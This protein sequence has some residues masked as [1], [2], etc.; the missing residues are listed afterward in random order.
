M[1]RELIF[2]IISGVCAVITDLTLYYLLIA[3]LGHEIAKGISFVSGSIVAYLLNKFL[4]FRKHQNS[5]KEVLRFVTLY[6]FTLSAN[7]TVNGLVLMILPSRVF[8]AFLGATGVS[9]I[10]NF[11]GQKFWVFR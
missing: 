10:L 2:F 8:F 4:T 9:T 5:L 3:S 7:V 6:F 11:I 1:K